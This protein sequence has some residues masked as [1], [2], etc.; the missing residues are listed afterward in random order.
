M[1]LGHRRDNG[2]N[3]NWLLPKSQWE[4]EEKI[5]VI[6]NLQLFTL[7]YWCTLMC[8][9]VTTYCAD[10]FSHLLAKL[11]LAEPYLDKGQG[12]IDNDR[13]PFRC[14]NSNAIMCYPIIRHPRKSPCT[15][16]RARWLI[17]PVRM[18]THLV[19]LILQIE[20]SSGSIASKTMTKTDTVPS[21]R[22]LWLK[23]CKHAQAAA[24]FPETNPLIQE[25]L[26]P[27]HQI[28]V[29]GRPE[30]VSSCLTPKTWW[31]ENEPANLD[32]RWHRMTWATGLSALL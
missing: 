24:V 4:N 30:T 15:H 13:H 7:H 16:E 2:S 28:M 3:G 18:T 32:S 8:R 12:W 22:E 27:P 14:C 21:I 26:C 1:F 9:K 10:I 23:G 29:L 31:Q 5:S 6:S 19:C 17:W 11:D 25:S 20:E